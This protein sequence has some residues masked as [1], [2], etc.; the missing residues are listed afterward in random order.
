M[1]LTVDVRDLLCE[2]GASRTVVINE[3]VPALA[4]E[5]ARIPEERPVA[6]EFLIESVVDGLIVSGA[7]RGTMTLACARCLEPF[8]SEARVEVHEPFVA[9]AAPDADEYPVADGFAD[10]EPMI[11]DS[12]VL[13]M[14]FA[15]LCKPSCL[16]LCAGCGGNRN[17]GECRCEQEAD[18][19]WSA[20][21]DLNVSD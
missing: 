13:A 20:L 12:I 1:S 21:Q 2:P 7:I 14:P 5:L 3:G 16:G 9:G 19:R 11:R 18:P 4:T 17:L 10:L 6:G 15:P 8:E